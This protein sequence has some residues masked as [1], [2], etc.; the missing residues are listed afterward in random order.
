MKRL[1]DYLNA[2]ERFCCTSAQHVD[3]LLLGFLA[4]QETIYVRFACIIISFV[5]LCVL[6]GDGARY[7]RARKGMSL[8]QTR[9]ECFRASCRAD[10]RP[11]P[12]L[13]RADSRADAGKRTTQDGESSPVEEQKSI[14]PL[15]ASD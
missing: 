8:I 2:G 9:T 4:Q 12:R 6:L 13:R 14:T 3:D 11:K 5:F 7:R 10:R 15:G 1:L